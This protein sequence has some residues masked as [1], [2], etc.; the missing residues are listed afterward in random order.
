M[1]NTKRFL[2]ATAILL[3]VLLVALVWGAWRFLDDMFPLAPPAPVLSAEEVLDYSL[4]TQDGTALP[5]SRENLSLL[6]SAV[7]Q[8]KPTR[9]QS[10]NDHPDRSPYYELRLETTERPYCLYF[11][12]TGV[13]ASS[14][15]GLE[16]PYEG[17]WQLQEDV[18]WLL[19]QE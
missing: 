1:K 11:F 12:S 14:V 16:S 4:T 9:N 18:L 15:L 7:A 3:A 17:I 6:L 13:G 19:L 10:L 5:L 2:S 8:A